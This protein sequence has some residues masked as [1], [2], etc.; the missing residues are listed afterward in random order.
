MRGTVV[1]PVV[2]YVLGLG[3]FAMT[4]SEFMV[5]GMLPE[6]STDLGV[7]ISAIG[8]LVS[9]CAVARALGGPFVSAGLAKLSRWRSLAILL[10]SFLA[11][12]VLGAVATGYPML[13]ASRLVTG[14]AEAAFFGVS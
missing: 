9:A 4:T 1:M 6:L 3:I 13:M 11:G 12:Q 7:S 5:A 10:G 8:Y 14:S 2:V